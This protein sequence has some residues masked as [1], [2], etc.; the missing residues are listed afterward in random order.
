LA[1]DTQIPAADGPP[2]SRRALTEGRDG[3][4]YLYVAPGVFGAEPLLD[5]YDPVTH[6][7]ER[8]VL[9]LDHTGRVTLAA[10]RDALW[11]A[12][13]RGHHQ[14][15]RIPWP[16]LAALPWHPVPDLHLDGTPI[17]P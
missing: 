6:R 2:G 10:G 1:S 13:V 4:V 3:A 17:A 5:R 8:A 11:I 16:T 14:L 7:L 15:W 9:A 12:A